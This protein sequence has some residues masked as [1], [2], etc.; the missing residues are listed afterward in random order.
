ML[1]ESARRGKSSTR[2]VRS[3]FSSEIVMTDRALPGLARVYPRRL[4]NTSFLPT[5]PTAAAA[6]KRNRTL[7]L[8]FRKTSLGT[9]FEDQIERRLR[10]AVES[11]K[12]ARGDNFAEPLLSGLCAERQADFLG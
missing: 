1:A 6:A 11:G 12:T 4:A 3:I 5:A 9:R 8:C 2:D 10:G 7:V